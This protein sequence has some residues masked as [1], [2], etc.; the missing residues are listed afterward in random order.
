LKIVASTNG[1][2]LSNLNPTQRAIIIKTMKEQGFIKGFTD[3]EIILPKGITLYIEL[4]KPGRV[5][6]LSKEQVEFR[7]DLIRLEH[8]VYCT[9]D[10]N[11]FFKIINSHLTKEYREELFNNYKGRFKSFAKQQYGLG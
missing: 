9:N 11:E 3:L 2:N 7:D 10:L 6:G 5:G 8:K 1:I 4:K